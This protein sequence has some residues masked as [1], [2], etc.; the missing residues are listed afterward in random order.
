MRINA[1]YYFHD[2]IEALKAKGHVEGTDLFGFGYDFRQSNRLPAALGAYKARIEDISARNQGRKV[3][4]VTHSMGGLLT[5]ALLA[6][7]PETFAAHV[8][9]W[10]AVACPFA[11]APGFTMDA[12]VSGTQ[13]LS[14]WEQYWFVNRWTMHQTLQECPSVYEMMPDPSTKWSLDPT[15]TVWL[16][17]GE[18]G[19]GEERRVTVQT[20][21]GLLEEVLRDN[22]VSRGGKTTPLPLN[23]A[24]VKW[25]AGTRSLLKKAKLPKSTSFYN[26]C[27]RGF[28]TAQSVTYGTE[29]APLK[30]LQELEKGGGQYEHVKGDAT[31]PF[32]SAMAD[33]LH[34]RGRYEVDGTTD[35][36][37][38]GLLRNKDV[39]AKVLGWL[40]E[41]S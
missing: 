6:A 8:R 41:G 24:L 34:A 37:H 25:A 1:V 16:A 10:V 4:I 29:D 20:F 27:G 21:Y 23:P 31:V 12:L 5:K 9:T 18:G 11:G 7:H 35:G 30:S 33:G 19:K 38:Q 28:D 26:V 13:F 17:A 3:D 32:E 2:M 40:G 36:D 14:G 22:S 39:L 15:L